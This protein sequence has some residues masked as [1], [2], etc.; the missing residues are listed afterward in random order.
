MLNL[1][2]EERR[3]AIASSGHISGVG[4]PPGGSKILNLRSKISDLRSKNTVYCLLYTVLKGDGKSALSARE[5]ATHHRS[6]LR[7]RSGGGWRPDA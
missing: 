4:G 6:C 2:G 3:L 5:V 7:G 1:I